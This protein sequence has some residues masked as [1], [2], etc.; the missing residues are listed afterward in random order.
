MLVIVNACIIKNIAELIDEKIDLKNP[1]NILRIALIGKYAEISIL[2]SS[3]IFS[4]RGLCP[5]YWSMRWIR[6]ERDL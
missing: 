6:K 2:K 3:D 4:V 5:K 1:D